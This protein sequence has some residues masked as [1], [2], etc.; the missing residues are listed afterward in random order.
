ML[1]Y[2]MLCYVMLCYVMSLQVVF[3]GMFCVSPE[4]DFSKEEMPPVTLL[5]F[6]QYL[7]LLAQLQQLLVLSP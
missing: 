2:V 4:E 5:F 1:C 7:P 6:W 3:I